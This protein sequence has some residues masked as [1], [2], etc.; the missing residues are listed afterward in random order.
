MRQNPVTNTITLT[1]TSRTFCNRLVPS[2]CVVCFTTHT[3]TPHDCPQAVDNDASLSGIHDAAEKFDPRTEQVRCAANHKLVQPLA[4]NAWTCCL[5]VALD[6]DPAGQSCIPTAVWPYICLH[7]LCKACVQ[8]VQH[9]SWL[10]HLV[11]LSEDVYML[12]VVPSLPPPTSLPCA[13]R[14]SS[15]CR[16]SL[17]RP[18][19]LLTEPMMWP[20]LW[21]PL[22]LSTVRSTAHCQALG[23][24]HGGRAAC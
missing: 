4:T 6:K 16:S 24:G 10:F 8:V 12:T 2:P 22:L 19:L 21:D 11:L 9:I 14:C 23:R 20:M 13:C 18:C 1:D 3:L 15:T 5:W 17:L 7:S